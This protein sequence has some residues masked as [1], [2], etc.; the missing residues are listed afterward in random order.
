MINLK[1]KVALISGASRG[2][3]KATALILARTGAKVVINYNKSKNIVILLKECQKFRIKA[4]PFKADISSESECRKMVNFT[5][6]N[7]GKIDILVN[8]AGVWTYAPIDKMPDKVLDETLDIN[9]RGVF[10]LTREVVP[11]MK[12]QKSG[13]IINISSTAGQR[14]EVDHSHYAATKGAIISL[15]KSLATELALWNIRVNCVAPG[16]VYTDMSKDALKSKERKRILSTIPLRRVG[17]PEEIAG[18]VLFLTSDLASF[19]TG[20]ILN[21]NGGAVLCG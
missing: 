13:N 6:E 3:G 4:L 2:I 19:I 14:G 8:N 12:K 15:T 16:W 18:A 1:N 17:T 20:E 9:L 11:Y 7:F 10:Y 21:V 5:I